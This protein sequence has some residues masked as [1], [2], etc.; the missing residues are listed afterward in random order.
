MNKLQYAVMDCQDYASILA[1]WKL[2]PEAN[3]T[4]ADDEEKIAFYLT[5]NLNQSFVCKVGVEIV[6][7]VLCGNDGR[8]AFIY[9]LV[10]H[11]NY[12]KQGIGRHLVNLAI[13]TQKAIG[14]ERVV[15]F[16]KK[17]NKEG[18]AFWKQCGF[19]KHAE[20]DTMSTGI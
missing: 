18:V 15:L 12:R 7:T 5:H 4:S 8:R 14:I 16:V 20:I 19:T 11:E 10:V 2:T 3:L 13:Q 9:H 6:G 17:D 1:L